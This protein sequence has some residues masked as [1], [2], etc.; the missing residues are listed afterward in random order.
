LKPLF[1]KEASLLSDLVEILS[2]GIRQRIKSIYVFGSV[3]RAEDTAAS[4]IDI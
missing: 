3:A 4:D 2:S 1:E